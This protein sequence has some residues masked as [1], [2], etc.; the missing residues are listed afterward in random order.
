MAVYRIVC[1]DYG[2]ADEFA[3][4]RHIVTVGTG[5]DVGKPTRRWTLQELLNALS[6]GDQFYTYAEGRRVEVLSVPCRCGAAT[7]STMDD[8]P[9]TARIDALPSCTEGASEEHLRPAEA[10]G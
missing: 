2:P 6:S 7:V 8:D 3:S 1:A 10:A 5:G 9:P 4:H